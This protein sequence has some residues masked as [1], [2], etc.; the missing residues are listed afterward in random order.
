MTEKES[1]SD[2]LNL[3]KKEV[4]KLRLQAGLRKALSAELAK[5][6]K[7]RKRPQHKRKNRLK[8]SKTF[9]KTCHDMSR[10]KFTK[11]YLIGKTRLN[12]AANGK[13]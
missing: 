12:S 11:S 9:R 6:K 5:Q 3:L 10:P 7:S 2:E 1:V 4:G 13:S 8:S